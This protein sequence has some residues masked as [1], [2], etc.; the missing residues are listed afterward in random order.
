MDSSRELGRA[1]KNCFRQSIF[2]AFCRI[3]EASGCWLYR[4]RVVKQKGDP[5]LQLN[6]FSFYYR[7]QSISCMVT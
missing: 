1:G 3:F 7:M 4:C 2:H 6:Y 5:I